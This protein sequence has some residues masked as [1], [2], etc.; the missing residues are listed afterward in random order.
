M[1]SFV[2]TILA[3]AVVVV[4]VTALATVFSVATKA[5]PTGVVSSLQPPVVAA[6]RGGMAVHPEN[7][8]AAFE[9]VAANHPGVALEMDVRRLGDG[10]LVLSHDATITTSSGTRSL[11]SM[12]ESEW[13]ATRV[14]DP[15]GG[16]AP[17][18]TLGD[19]LDRF[20]DRDILLVIELKEAPAA[21]AFIEAVWDYR[22]QVLVQSFSEKVTSRFVRSGLHALQLSTTANFTIVDGV[23]SVGVKNSAI[24]A[25]LITRAH[26]DGVLVW[27]WGDG[28][29]MDLV[30]T[31]TRDVDGYMVDDPR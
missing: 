22:D 3:A 7:T 18:S 1:S 21:G 6:H 2:R 31:D 26:T 27:A 20:G 5:E 25:D 29:T 14:P 30:D 10:T 16:S 23:H 28:T 9:D 11:S 12:T 17:R 15:Q 24:T 8:M 13:R 4:A 19:V